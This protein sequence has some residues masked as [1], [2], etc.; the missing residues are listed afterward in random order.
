MNVRTDPTAMRVLVFAPF[1]RDG[2]LAA[3]VLEATGVWVEVCAS[4]DELCEGI[5][6]G[7]AA[8][9]LTEE[10]LTAA[11]E[12]RLR[13]V[14][15]S[16]PPWSDLP[17]ILCAT[18]G[19][20]SRAVSLRVRA[21]ERAQNVVVLERPMQARTLV[22]AVHAALRARAR[23]CEVRDLVAGLE[24]ARRSA[25]EASRSKDEFLA[26][27]S[28]ELRTPLNAILG[29]SKL[30]ADGN[31]AAPQQAKA[32][33]TIERNAV[34]QAKLID[35]LL[36]VARILSRKLEVHK[37][38]IALAPVVEAALEATRHLGEAKRVT[39]VA[40]LDPA[41]E[42]LA[43][44]DRM[45]QIVTNIVG[46]AIKFSHPDGKVEVKLV[47]DGA[48]AKLTVRDEGAGIHPSFLPHV[49]D[50]FRQED[51]SRTRKH[52]GLGLGLAIVHHLVDLQGGKVFADSEGQGRGA[53]FTIS[54]PLAA[55]D[56]PRSVTMT[57]R[58]AMSRVLEGLRVVVVD[59]DIDAVE[60][61]AAILEGAG[62]EVTIATNAAN[63]FAAVQAAPPAV[64]VSDIAMPGDDGYALVE[65]IRR[66]DEAQGRDVPAIAVT[67]F[68]RSEDRAHALRSGFDAHLAKPID[69][70]ELVSLVASLSTRE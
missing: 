6:A 22:A 10:S 58:S 52:G 61:V 14:I 7:A 57:G 43:D 51:G 56:A 47:R 63:A 23:Q 30:L 67:A 70:A 40:D 21:F 55:E 53:T 28:H 1:G 45:V 29:W 15:D 2:E 44:P 33:A 54:L 20:A 24:A 9:I 27:V 69:P 46:N 42:I 13:E 49:F 48:N 25:E 60:L 4:T 37:R 3:R 18:T 8:L 64:L 68:S 35:E 19:E 36:D 38:R 34:A 16:E 50:R 32:R 17:L 26:M 66:L 11:T 39:P 65:R 5:K 59:D 12:K 31:L 62:A 41:V